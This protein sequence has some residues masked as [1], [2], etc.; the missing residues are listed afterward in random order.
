M[1]QHAERLAERVTEGSEQLTGRVA[2]RGVDRR[3][4]Q[5]HRPDQFRPP[6]SKLGHDLAAHRV[7]DERR[8]HEAVRLHPASQGPRETSECRSS[9]QVAALPLARQVGDERRERRGERSSEWQHVSAGDPEAVNEHDR[10]PVA[11]DDLAPALDANLGDTRTHRPEP[12]DAD[13]PDLMRHDPR[14]Y[15]ADESALALCESNCCNTPLVM[16]GLPYGETFGSLEAPAA[17]GEW[18]DLG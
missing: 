5:D 13:L 3:T 1:C 18:S 8:P 6:E 14:W 16:R 12:D 4:D 2:T 7:R 15:S 17:R 9:A 10:R 11:H